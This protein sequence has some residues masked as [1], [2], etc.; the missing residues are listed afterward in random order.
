[1]DRRTARSVSDSFLRQLV[2]AVDGQ[3]ADAPA[4]DIT[5]NKPFCQEMLR[6]VAVKVVGSLAQYIPHRLAHFGEKTV[7]KSL[8]L[9]LHAT[10]IPSEEH[11]TAIRKLEAA[12]AILM[13]AKRAKN[14]LD[15]P[16]QEA[17]NAAMDKLL[18]E[19]W[20]ATRVAA[21]VRIVPLQIRKF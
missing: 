9:Q 10:P 14:P 18:F 13:I 5:E 20:E 7:L 8:R 17:C 16:I 15:F 4:R 2:N 6:M 11:A 3:V 21:T 1:M 19:D 12:T